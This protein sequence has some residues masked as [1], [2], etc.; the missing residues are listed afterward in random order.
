M[1]DILAEMSRAAAAGDP[2]AFVRANW[3]LHAAIAAVSPHPVLRSLYTSLLDLIESHTLSVLPAGEQPP[4]DPIAHRHAMH[5]DLIDAIADRDRDRA[6]SL[7]AE[8]NTSN[9]SRH[10]LLN[11][12]AEGTDQ[13]RGPG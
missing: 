2:T 3:H 9:P 10:Q 1:R 12:R 11:A 8:H 13:R 4:A 6:M 7:I 5:A